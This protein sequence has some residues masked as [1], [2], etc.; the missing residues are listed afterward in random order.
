M[1]LIKEPLNFIANKH[2]TSSRILV[3]NHWSRRICE[4]FII[5]IITVF[6][7]FEL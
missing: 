2:I 7:F 1:F 3:E 6:F 4:Y 5:I